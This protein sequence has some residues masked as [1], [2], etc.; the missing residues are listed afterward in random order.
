MPNPFDRRVAQKIGQ[1]APGHA[2]AYY[3]Q[4]V[5]G[6]FP[7]GGGF[8]L[9][10]FQPPVTAPTGSYRI[11]YTLATNDSSAL[12]QVPQGAPAPTVEIY[13]PYTLD[14]QKTNAHQ[15]AQETKQE[16]KQAA[17][18]K[19]QDDPQHVRDRIEYQAAV[20]A[21]DLDENKV[22]LGR[23]MRQA[24]EGV[25]GLVLARAYRRELITTAERFAPFMEQQLQMFEKMTALQ[26]AMTERV[27]VQAN[28][29]ALAQSQMALQQAPRPRDTLGEFMPTLLALGTTIARGYFGQGL[30]EEEEASVEGDLDDAKLDDDNKALLKKKKE[31]LAR[32]NKIKGSESQA[33]D[34]RKTKEQAKG[35][36]PK[37]MGEASAAASGSK[38]AKG[39]KESKSSSAGAKKAPAGP[40]G[41]VGRAKSKKAVAK[42]SRAE[43]KRIKGVLGSGSPA[44]S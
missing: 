31:L 21:N 20:F 4:S 14:S 17:R 24:T 28:A 12:E 8:L 42:K 5:L 26:L 10:P 40:A 34:K 19:W 37:K 41:K 15:I 22:L 1:H 6:R 30:P 18:E 36:P 38:K 11:Y 16:L 7:S 2:R 13:D 3:L 29:Q 23:K 39:K 32:L 9:D 43:G 27:Q 25:E 33:P 35:S 44:K